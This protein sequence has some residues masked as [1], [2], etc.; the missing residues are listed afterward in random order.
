MSTQLTE[1]LEVASRILLRCWI[2]GFLVLLF[3]FGVF[4]LA[5]DLVCRVHGAMFGLTPHELK[6]IH[7]CGM[8]LLK[9]AVGC[10]FLFPWLAI[11]MVLSKAR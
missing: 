7:Y 5:E 9:L 4:M 3:W 8:G 10:F 1:W 11:R 6:V 2:F